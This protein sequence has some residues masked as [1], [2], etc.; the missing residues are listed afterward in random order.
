MEVESIAG[1]PVA[2]GDVLHAVVHL[3]V[4]VRGPLAANASPGAVEELGNAIG[5]R[6]RVVGVGV[7]RNRRGTGTS[8]LLVPQPDQ[9]CIVGI[10]PAVLPEPGLGVSAIT[11]RVTG[12][13]R[14][15][16]PGRCLTL[17]ALNHAA[18]LG[19]RRGEAGSLVGDVAGRGCDLGGLG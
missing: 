3:P 4:R 10:G 7:P 13:T 16:S 6:S 9:S 12:T 8:G 18:E 2:L 14:S 5:G 1:V 19:R 17:A 15:Q 11:V